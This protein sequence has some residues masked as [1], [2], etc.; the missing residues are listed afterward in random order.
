MITIY[1]NPRCSTSRQT[2]EILH[3]RKD[4]VKVIEYL[5]NPPDKKELQQILKYLGLPASQLIRKKEELFKEKY[6]DKKLSEA[7]WLDVMIKNPILI[8]R[9]IVIKGK[10]AIIGRPSEN[11]FQ[12]L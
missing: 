1:H 6:K 7:E 8:E 2:L 3:K 4:E 11:G 5:K 12:I 10:K 9:P